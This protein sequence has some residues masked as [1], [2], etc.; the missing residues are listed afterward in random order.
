M[1]L[2]NDEVGEFRYAVN[3]TADP[4]PPSEL[5]SMSAELG[6]S[7]RQVSLWGHQAVRTPLPA[8]RSFGRW[9]WRSHANRL[10]PPSNSF[11]PPV[12][13]LRPQAFSLE[14]PLDTPVVLT[15][16]SS[17]PSRFAISPQLVSR[18]GCIRGSAVTVCCGVVWCDRRS[19]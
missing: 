5:P 8:Q 3:M 13:R 16:S 9:G 17:N 11:Q 14:N 19:L 2:V 1:I 6:R 4:A 15:T 18:Q 12:N 7:T 10:R